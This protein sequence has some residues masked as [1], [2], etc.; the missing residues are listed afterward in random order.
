MTA[1]GASIAVPEA[2]EAMSRIL[3]EFVEI[4][5]LHRKAS[6][7]IARPD[8]GKPATSRPR[9]RPESRCSVAGCMTGA[10]LARIERLP[11]A[12]GM[13]DEVVIMTGTWS[14]TARR[15]SRRSGSPE[16]R[17]CRSGSR[18]WRA[19]T[20]SK[21][22][23][24][25]RPLPRSTSCRTTRCSTGKSRS[26]I[27][28]HLQREKRAGDRRCRVRVRPERFLADGAAIA[29][30]SAHKISWRPDRRDRRGP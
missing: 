9:P 2:V 20:S 27:L 28:P 18:R 19:A 5:D 10:D 30:Y 7:A 12:A 25:T 13:K 4:N 15:S 24:P 14:A 21:G 29:I 23:S 17:S 1:L 6:A 11:D 26:G 8:E 16:P 3:P 22:R